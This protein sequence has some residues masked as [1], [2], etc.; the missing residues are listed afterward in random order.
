MKFQVLVEPNGATGSYVLYSK[1]SGQAIGTVNA[2]GQVTSVLGNGDTSTGIADPLTPIARAIIEQ[3]LQT[4]FPNYVPNANP[5]SGPGGG[6]SPGDP[7]SGTSPDPLKFIIPDFLPNQPYTV[8][9]KLQGDGSN[10][11]PIDV[12]FTRFNTAPII[13][14]TPGR[15][16]AAGQPEQLRYQGPGPDHRSRHW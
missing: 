1:T 15:R 2:A 5:R 16:H 7:N 14:V 6:S 3:T 4:Y 8:P 12:T 9:I 11:S 10:T 13:T